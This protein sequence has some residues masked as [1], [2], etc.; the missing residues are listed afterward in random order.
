MREVYVNVVGGLKV[1]DPDADLAVAVTIV[2]S[3][4]GRPIRPGTAFIGSVDIYLLSVILID[5]VR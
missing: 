2:S 4:V 5:F 1:N 3:Y